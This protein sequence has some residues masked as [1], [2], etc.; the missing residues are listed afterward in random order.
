MLLLGTEAQ[1]PSAAA[2]GHRLSHKATILDCADKLLRNGQLH[3]VC[4]SFAWHD[5]IYLRGLGSRN[6]HI[7]RLL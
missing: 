1:Q 4:I 3:W 7:Q 6:G 5:Q 2:V